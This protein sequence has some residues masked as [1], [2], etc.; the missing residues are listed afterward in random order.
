MALLGLTAEVPG[1]SQGPNNI[2][3]QAPLLFH[4]CL[5]CC[6][7]FLKLQDSRY[8]Y[9]CITLVHTYAC[10]CMH[11]H[12]HT[13][14]KPAHQQ[15]HACSSI[16]QRRS[17]CWWWLGKQLCKSLVSVF[18][19][20]SRLF[21]LRLWICAVYMKG[22]SDMQTHAHPHNVACETQAINIIHLSTNLSSFFFAFISTVL[23]FDPR[24][25]FLNLQHP[26]LCALHFIN[27][28]LYHSHR[29]NTFFLGNEDIVES[30]SFDGPDAA[31]VFHVR[32]SLDS[33]IAVR[34]KRKVLLSSE[35]SI[36]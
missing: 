12:K 15:A 3:A 26:H 7:W 19:S 25:N 18:D 17:V 8:A 36:M 6:E 2:S 5:Y 35:C 32:C 21:Y 10:I 14:V 22:Y 28:A 24:W 20:H 11:V 27:Q 33:V 16:G 29:P 1:F 30:I 23:G 34:A 13:W 4:S 31:V 9:I